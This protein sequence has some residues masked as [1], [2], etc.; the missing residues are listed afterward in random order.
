MDGPEYQ[1][2][3]SAPSAEGFDIPDIEH[4]LDE[5]LAFPLPLGGPMDHQAGATV[6]RD[7]LDDP[8][9][10]LARYLKAEVLFVEANGRFHVMA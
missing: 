2:F 3:L 6:L 5:G 7:Q 10:R 4:Q 9:A 8:V 1:P